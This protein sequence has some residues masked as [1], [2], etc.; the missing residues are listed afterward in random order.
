MVGMSVGWEE[1]QGKLH[2]TREIEIQI[3]NARL[4]ICMQTL[5]MLK[6]THVNVLTNHYSR[7]KLFPRAQA[8]SQESAFSCVNLLNDTL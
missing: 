3:M 4:I 2:P 8:L 6:A 1:I 5:I 7:V